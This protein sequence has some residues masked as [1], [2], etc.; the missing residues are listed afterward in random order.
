MHREGR[1]CD[2][3]NGVD[4]LLAAAVIIAQ[5]LRIVTMSLLG[6]SARVPLALLVVGIYLLGTMTGGGLLALLRQS[7][8]EAKRGWRARRN[9]ACASA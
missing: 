7:I 1:S 9:A 5:N 3:S 4:C 8:E 6:F 2:D